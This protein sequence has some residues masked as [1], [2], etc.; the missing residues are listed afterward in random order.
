MVGAKQS[1]VQSRRMR[2]RVRMRMR[3]RNIREWTE[4]GQERMSRKGCTDDG[5]I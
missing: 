1:R 3:I 2:A 4:Q 5:W